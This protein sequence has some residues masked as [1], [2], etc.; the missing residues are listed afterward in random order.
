MNEQKRSKYDPITDYTIFTKRTT[1]KIRP[2]NF[3][4][5]SYLQEERNFHLRRHLGISEILKHHKCV[6]LQ[7]DKPENM[8]INVTLS[9]RLISMISN[10]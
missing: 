1:D 5:P 3:D 4:R 9:N 2:F 8:D 10:R 6:N 7:Y